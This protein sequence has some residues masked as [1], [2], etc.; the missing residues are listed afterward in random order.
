MDN[1][2]DIWKSLSMKEKGNIIRV[3]VNHGITNLNDIKKA[4]YQ[5]ADGGILDEQPSEEIPPTK[6]KKSFDTWYKTVPSD[7]N[8]TINY[9]LRRAY[10]LAPYEE[11]EAWRNSSLEDLEK[12]NNHL[13]SVYLNPDTGIYEFVKSKNHPTLHYETDWYFSNAP[14]AVEFRKNYDLNTDGY[15]YKYVPRK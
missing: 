13:R 2:N 6:K 5:F 14:D 11:L 7:R 15:Y 9:N 1:N 12:G 4:Y 10:E 3:A 8:D